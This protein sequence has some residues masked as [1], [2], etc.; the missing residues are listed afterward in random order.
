MIG[1][2]LKKV[3]GQID[4]GSMSKLYG[5]DMDADDIAPGFTGFRILC[6]EARN[7]LERGK[8]YRG[9]WRDESIARGDPVTNAKHVIE[10]HVETRLKEALHYLDYGNVE[11]AFAALGS[12]VGFMSV[13][14]AQ[15]LVLAQKQTDEKWKR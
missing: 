4:G 2:V 15:T 14:V 1:I 8:G 10:I 5:Y 7:A 3:T 13:I 11:A 12:A 6:A 9:A